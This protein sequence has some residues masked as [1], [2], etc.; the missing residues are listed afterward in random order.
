MTVLQNKMKIC[1]PK[2]VA[3]IAVEFGCLDGCCWFFVV[4]AVVLFFVCLF[5]N[6]RNCKLH[7]YSLF[8]ASD[9]IRG[10][11]SFEL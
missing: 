4:V 1:P 3:S 5:K 2:M 11:E 10:S 8:T 6:T 7:I 9:N